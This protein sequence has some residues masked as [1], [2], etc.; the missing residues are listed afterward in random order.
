MGNAIAVT[1]GMMLKL[2]QWLFTFAI[3]WIVNP[4]LAQR[5]VWLFP[6]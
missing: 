6:Q 5:S 4:Y 2:I 3:A 1:S